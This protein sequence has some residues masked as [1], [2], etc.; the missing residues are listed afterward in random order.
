MSETKVCCEKSDGNVKQGVMYGLIPHAGCIAFIFASVFGVTVATEFF[1]PLLLN[2]YFFYILIGISFV[3]AS[4]SS[5]F[6]L[7][8]NGLL[9]FQGARRK[10]KYLSTM[11][12]STIGINLLMFLVIFPL[13]ANVSF[14]QSSTNI[15]ASNGI[16]SLA[17][18]KLQV[19]IPCSGHASLISGDLKALSGVTGVQFSLPNVFEVSYD[20]SKTTK[21]DILTLDVFKTYKATV[22]SESNQQ[23]IQSAALLSD[24]KAS[25]GCCGGSCDGSCG[26][27]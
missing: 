12:G 20:T 19:E 8:K 18:L 5:A 22:L 25:G 13:L 23:A 7:R 26:C 10:W 9:S 27:R 6:Y 24:T 15:S 4:V 16:G 17:S 1:K 2:P 3:F 14:A 21:Q 11:Y